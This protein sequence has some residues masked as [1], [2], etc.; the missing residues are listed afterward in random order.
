MSSH[1]ETAE[2]HADQDLQ[3][4]RV[5]T[6]KE[7]IYDEAKT[8]VGDLDGWKLVQADDDAL[9]LTCER[10]GGLLRAAAKVTI[11]VDG[12]D[13]IPSATVTVR[14]E[15]DG[16]LSRDKANVQEFLRPFRRRVC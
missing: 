3:P 11:R 5:P 15:T 6:R 13:G 14:S 16:G 1:F 4:L 8:M 7:E 10:K 9:V 2:G 12:P